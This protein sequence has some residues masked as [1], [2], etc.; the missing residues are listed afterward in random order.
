MIIKAVGSPHI[1]IAEQLNSIPIPKIY[2][3]DESYSSSIVSELKSY[4]IMPKMDFDSFVNWLNEEMGIREITVD[5][6]NLNHVKPVLLK[7][8]LEG[9]NELWKLE[10]NEK[11]RMFFEEYNRQGSLLSEEYSDNWIIIGYN[12]DLDVF[13]SNSVFLTN[14]LSYFRGIDPEDMQREWKEIYPIR[15]ALAYALNLDG[16]LRMYSGFRGIKTMQ[17]IMHTERLIISSQGKKSVTL[18]KESYQS[19]FKMIFDS[20]E[21]VIDTKYPLTEEDTEFCFAFSDTNNSTIIL[22]Y[23]SEKLYYG[24]QEYFELCKMSPQL[25]SW[26]KKIGVA[27]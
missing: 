10:N 23:G 15:T 17:K 14:V 1:T 24:Q 6:W 2:L 12:H 18:P 20:G 26:L 27:N 8:R 9:S 21:I 11:S 7:M 4:F 25:D 13:S 16:V 3:T 22:S 5:D 19:F